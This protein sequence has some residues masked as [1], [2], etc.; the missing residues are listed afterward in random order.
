MSPVDLV[1]S[2][3]KGVKRNGT[4][5]VALCPAHNDRQPSL[6][7]SEGDDCRAL[8]ICHRGCEFEAILG[9]LGLKAADLFASSRNGNPGR[10]IIA[11]YDYLNG[12][13]ELLFQVVRFDP[14]DFRQRRPHENGGWKWSLKGVSRILYRLPELLA[15]P[16]DEW[17][18]VV[19]GEKDADNLA[20]IGMVTTTCPQGAGKWRKLSD[21][22][23]LNGRRVAIIADRDVPGRSHAEDVAQ[24]L[25]GRVAELRA[26][27]LPGKG[28]DASD[29]LAAG[30]T[31]AQ[32][33]ELVEAAPFYA[34]H[35]SA[36]S[37]PP[38]PVGERASILID[39]DEHRVVCE[40]VAALIADP[41]IY[42][43]GGVLVRVVRTTSP[44]DGIVRAR[45]SA[46]ICALPPAN[47]RE[48]ITRFA[49]FTTLSRN[50]EIIPAHPASWLVSAIDAR[51]EWSGIRHLLGVSDAP[52]LRPDG[53]IWQT[54][55]YD[56]I[57]GVLYEPITAFPHIPDGIN[58]D[59]ADAAMIELAEVVSDFRFE[60]DEH[61]AAWLAGM[62]TPLAR[63]AYAGP[64]PLFLIDANV[65]G[66]GK[67][68]LAQTIGV[69][70]LGREMPVSSYAHDSEEMRKKIT[71]IAIAGDR[72]ILL[73]NLEGLFGN[74]SI[75]RALTSTIWKDRILGKSEQVELPLLPVWYATGNNVQVAADTT[76]RI[77]HIRLDVLE[78]HPEDRTGFRHPDLLAWI[79]QNR[80][81]LLTH[82][83]TILAA[84][85]RAGRPSQN[86][87]PFGSFEGWSSI[88]R[89]AVVWVGLPDPC[90][91]RTRLVESADTTADALAQLVSA[92]KRYDVD[93]GGFVVAELL[94]TLYPTQNAPDDE[95]S[96]A[97]RA[98]LENLVNCPA[99]K[100][101][102]AR[103]L[104]NR[105]R[106]FRR[107]VVDGVFLDTDAT[108]GE[109]GMRWRLQRSGG[110]K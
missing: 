15:A 9:A 72:L 1:R 93:L 67:G 38:A 110:A 86:L 65:R 89:E 30:G 94:N 66:A 24:R 51:G 78:E 64:S 62:L 43:R 13:R 69:I 48:R 98:A 7:L 14:K 109:Q 103:L 19:E 99:G 70:F 41:D 46:T 44:I 10:R 83:I 49:A 31:V 28:K 92:W 81:R 54:A 35:D 105:L 58:I 97:M 60:S 84:F 68:L 85:I 100:K 95:A 32:L 56:E 34:P 11:T 106:K 71:T 18:F 108:R 87:V 36:T 25:H 74:D 27:E 47:L 63:F 96:V 101:P 61:K 76:R 39:T 73:D 53:S 4:G 52:V 50:G 12:N 107:R 37:P 2:L 90:L 6:S 8:L 104:G 59:D 75:D 26:L 29:W 16:I 23:V 20:K 3:L 42:Q 102:S 80:G 91:T 55:G 79:A 40:T 82:A 45:G 77:I 21:D 17:I 57:T 22:T 88:V 33:R 5:Y